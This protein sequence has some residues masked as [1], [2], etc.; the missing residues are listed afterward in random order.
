MVIPTFSPDRGV[1]TY[2]HD[3]AGRLTR[4]TY[5]SGT[6]VEYAYTQGRI[7]RI[8]VNGQILLDHIGYAPFGPA[9]TWTWGNGQT[10]AR[11]YE[12]NGWIKQYPVANL[13]RTLA[14][15]RAGRITAYRHPGQANL[16]QTF[17]YNAIDQL[18]STTTYQ[19]SQ[20][21]RYDNNGNRNKHISGSTTYAYGYKTGNNRL[22]SVAG[23]VPKTYQY[24]AAGNITSDGQGLSYSYDDL[25][26]LRG[27]S[28]RKQTGDAI[29]TKA[30]GYTYDGLGQR[31]MKGGNAAG[32]IFY[33]YDE[34]G[35]LL[36]ERD[37]G[38][39]ASQDTIWLDD[40]PVGVVK[41]GQL[42]YIHADHLHTPRAILDPQNRPR[43]RWDNAD[44]FGVGQPD[45]NPSG[46]GRFVYN[47]R[48]PGQVYDAESGLH[49]NYYRDG[50]EPRTG[51]YT[52]GDPI[53]LAGGVNLY[54]Y[55]NGNPL[56]YTDPTGEFA[57]GGAL[58][59]AGID[60]GIQ[61]MSN[62][63]RFRCIKWDVVAISALAGAVN[64][65]SELSALSSAL[66]AEKQWARAKGLRPGGRAARR[67]AQR[68]D[69]HNSIAWK[70]GAS[71]AGIEAGA[72]LLGN[73]IPD[74]RHI[75]IGDPCEC[76]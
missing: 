50:Y 7:S 15:D 63:G 25:G 33:A 2:A 28:Q 53:G 57:I 26:R 54:A 68:G 22:Q 42:H 49:Y 70:E 34:T 44:P 8:T 29:T 65:F 11:S 1:T 18:Y 59:G 46:L 48:F 40:L 27:M 9:Q 5:P 43:W 38:N 35:R 75:R 61:L 21:Y 58:V 76:K 62:G 37:I 20:G 12:E 14:Y 36:S 30:M 41:Q 67:T 52:Q 72:E 56:M 32:V 23:P 64:P 74:D 69:K 71:W 13:N 45:E 6:L 66:K 31:F 3:P 60:I 51:R 17:N 24:D 47:P 19:G 16:D 4:L 39:V 55:V 10:Y 73:L